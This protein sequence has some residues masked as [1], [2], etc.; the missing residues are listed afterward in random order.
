MGFTIDNPRGVRRVIERLQDKSTAARLQVKPIAFARQDIEP[1][2]GV[3]RL[4]EVRE[5]LRGPLAHH[6][7]INRATDIAV[8]NSYCQ[9]VP[10]SRQVAGRDIITQEVGCPSSGAPVSVVFQPVDW[11]QASIAFYAEALRPL[12]AA[13]PAFHDNPDLIFVYLDP[14]GCIGMIGATTGTPKPSWLQFMNAL[15]GR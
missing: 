1:H 14:L 7:A 11:T 13:E 15:Q 5:R 12:L 9:N 3:Y 8:F 6:L 2:E 4:D 10:A